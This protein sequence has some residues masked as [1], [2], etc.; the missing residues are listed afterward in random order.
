MTHIPY[1]F[2]PLISHLTRTILGDKLLV[3]LLPSPSP[4]QSLWLIESTGQMNSSL[5]TLKPG[6]RR[7]AHLHLST[8]MKA[9]EKVLNDS[10]DDQDRKVVRRLASANA[11]LSSLYRNLVKPS[12]C[13]SPWLRPPTGSISRE[14]RKR[15]VL[16][17]P[18]EVEMDLGECLFG[19]AGG[20]RRAA[21]R[22]R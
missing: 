4:A 5:L 10:A 19:K 14:T 2:N 1:P 22:R 21:V 12:A 13:P 17:I 6:S 3:T 11:D 7:L 8:Q 16:W 20:R 9:V 18:K 15:S